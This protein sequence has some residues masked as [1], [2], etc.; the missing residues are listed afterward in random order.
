MQMVTI[1]GSTGSIGCNTL[2]V[3]ARH[4]DRFQVFALTAKQNI[5]RLFTQCVRFKPRYAVMVEADLAKQLSER[6]CE[7]QIAT[8][9]LAGS[10][11]IAQIA[12]DPASEIVMAAIVGAA[13]LLPT[14]AA[15]QS[16]KRVLLANKEALVMSGALL[17]NAVREN[18][19]TLLPVDSEHNA[20]FQ[21]MPAGFLPGVGHAD[22]VKSI[23]LTA[24]GGPFRTM[25]LA[26]LKNVTPE[27]A[28]AHP[29]WKMG[30]KI[31]IDS[32]TMMNKGLEVIEAYWLF[33][34]DIDQIKVVIHPQSIVHSMV[35]YQDSS[36]LAQLGCPDMRTPISNALAW[37]QRIVSGVSALDLVAAGCLEF[38][39]VSHTR[40]PC[41]SLAYQALKAGGTAMAVLNAANEVAVQAFRQKRIG[42]TQIAEVIDYVLQTLAA[43]PAECV[44]VII[45]ADQQARRAS[46]QYIG[47]K[48]N[49]ANA[50]LI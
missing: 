12:A 44:D 41:L 13:G 16:G 43:V 3:I 17:I 28:I 32:A 22:G 11:A 33:N 30:P 47:I 10:E 18:Q 35:E 31:S 37:P 6:L 45:A 50:Y 36:M 48:G 1:L 20:I 34:I 2:D 19:A 39:A 26:D 7:A 5:E 25:P 21:C 23:T 27:Q 38:E 14:L 9:V 40:S 29:N 8:E 24:S 46:A 42:Y 15:V 4:P 49:V